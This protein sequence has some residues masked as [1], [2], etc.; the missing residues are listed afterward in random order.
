[1][2]LPGRVVRKV[3]NMGRY[4]RAARAARAQTPGLNT[5]VVRR[6]DM[7]ARAQPDQY[8]VAGHA[9]LEA[10]ERGVTA[11]GVGAPKTI[12]DLPSGYGRVLR[13][14]MVRWPDADFT[15]CE[16]MPDGVEFCASEFGV[17]PLVSRD[18]L[19][20]VD[21]GGPYDL[22]WSGS[23][24]THFDVPYW[25][26]TLAHLAGALAPG[27]ALVFSTQG[28]PALGFLSGSPDYPVLTR[29]LP[30]NYGLPRDRAD[31]LVKD[32]QE[33]GFGFAHYAGSEES[34]YGT[35]ISLPDWVTE[36]LR[37]AGLDVV[38]HETG[39][40]GGHQDVWTTVARTT[41]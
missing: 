39:G 21:L 41:D 14:L 26:P 23:L 4:R 1:M 32:V 2:A 12:L 37:E 10:I 9:A 7:M 5:R 27:G 18:P 31:A 20:D 19:W 15:A 34:P 17:R 13:Y 29:V 3:R 22:I 35:S 36:R 33:T 38:L 11:A 8:F 30:P 24:F 16:L 6:D 25:T 40:W 28:E